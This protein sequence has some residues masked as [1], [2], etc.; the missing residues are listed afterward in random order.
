MNTYSIRAFIPPLT[1]RC[2]PI[3]TARR[4]AIQAP[5]APTMEIFSHQHKWMQKERAASD[6]ETSRGVDYLRDEVASRLCERLL[7]C[8]TSRFS[9]AFA[10]LCQDI[11]RHFP[12]VL[13]LGAN[14]CNIARMLTF[15]SDDQPDK[16][17]RSQRVGK[18]TAA[19]SSETLLYRDAD[20]PFNKELDIQR[21]VLKS[22]ETIPYDAGTF[23][24][25][26]SSLSL[27]WVNDLQTTTTLA[28]SGKAPNG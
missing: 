20:L 6:V 22:S 14:A 21:E 18:I 5:G 23:D 19:D 26:L 2:L 3:R 12:H 9:R 24:A 15:P 16:G 28:R 25:V 7:V 17:P 11:N 8:C 13:D 10:K 1:R 27:H 4:Y